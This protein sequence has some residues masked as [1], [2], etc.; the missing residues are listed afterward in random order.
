[1]LRERTTMLYI[2]RTTTHALFGNMDDAT[3][4]WSRLKEDEPDAYVRE[5]IRD[6]NEGLYVHLRTCSIDA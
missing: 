5:P 1:M 3:A 2:L 4:Y 6:P